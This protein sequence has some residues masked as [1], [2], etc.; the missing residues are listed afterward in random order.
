MES[1]EKAVELL[2]EVIDDSYV[3]KNIRDICKKAHTR[4]VNKDERVHIRMGAAICMLD[5]LSQD[6]NLPFNTRTKIWE[7]ASLL[8]TG[9]TN[10]K[11]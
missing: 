2:S 8:E 6:P 7:V 4:L 9:C 3:P 5:E 11:C 1:L 10:C